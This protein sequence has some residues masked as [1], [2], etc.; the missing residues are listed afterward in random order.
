MGEP[1]GALAQISGTPLSPEYLN[2]WQPR[3]AYGRVAD[4]FM[5][6]SG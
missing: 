1:P 4:F 2:V 3:V 6:G 5:Y